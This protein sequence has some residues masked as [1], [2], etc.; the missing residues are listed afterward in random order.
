M[1]GK[2]LKREALLSDYLNNREGPHVLCSDNMGQAK[3]YP[4][5]NVLILDWRFG[6]HPAFQS[7]LVARRLVCILATAWSISQTSYLRPNMQS[8]KQTEVLLIRIW[9]YP[10]VMIRKI[11]AFVGDRVGMR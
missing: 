10:Y 7:V 3:R 5:D 2:S 6:L 1:T 11:C 4:Y 8:R 9:R